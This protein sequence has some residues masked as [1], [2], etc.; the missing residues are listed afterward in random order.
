MKKIKELI[1]R[2]FA[3]HEETRVVFSDNI[4]TFVGESDQGKS[5]LLK[6]LLL[7]VKNELDFKNY[8]TI[9]L[10]KKYPAEITVI[11]MD[12]SF[13]R[14][15]KS[16]TINSYDL[17]YIE[18]DQEIITYNATSFGVNMPKKVE[19]FINSRNIEID[20]DYELN[21]NFSKQMEMPFLFNPKQDKNSTK[22]KLINT[23]ADIQEFDIALQNS[24]RKSKNYNLDVKNFEKAINEKQKE[25]DDY[26]NVDRKKILLDMIKEK[27]DNIES[28]KKLINDIKLIQ[29]NLV[30]IDK[31]IQ[32]N[33]KIIENKDNLNKIETLLNNIEN[34]NTK[35]D[36]LLYIQSDL[37]KI[38]KEYKYFNS[39]KDKKNDIEKMSNI[40]D[41]ILL[42]KENLSIK[43][44]K[45]QIISFTNK[46]LIA[47]NENIEYAKNII[48]KKPM[49]KKQDEILDK[50][51][52][53]ILTI[54]KNKDNLINISKVNVEVKNIDKYIDKI[55]VI[56][57]NKNKL[58]LATEKID[59]LEKKIINKIK[60]EEEN[61]KLDE[62]NE[63]ILK[64]GKYI[65]NEKLS[66]DKL[67][68]D[69]II[70]L[71]SIG[72]CPL[73][74]SKLTEEHLHEVIQEL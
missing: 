45:L 32:Y 25:L 20:K 66:Y 31:D 71:K 40:L 35:K 50:I 2:Y 62:L 14:R 49:I 7:C 58:K 16:K 41:K 18:K 8:M 30:S 1:I 65:L 70:E 3:C 53:K 42:L 4:T 48:S 15:T 54:N 47:L 52:E 28:K 60:L 57:E 23:L 55:K 64:G 59:V 67:K 17:G 43:R 74:M 33:S 5:M 29:N 68:E 13:V 9:G 19:E 27:I 11:F 6:G 69:Y 61:K 10:D 39:I 73:C 63:R 44:E 12:N 21:L 56:L 51:T 38:N 46:E 37:E 72:K 26:K 22:A 36:S 34:M 24:N